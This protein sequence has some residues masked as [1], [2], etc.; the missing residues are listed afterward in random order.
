MKA[1][2]RTTKAYRALNSLYN[3]GL[4]QATKETTCPYCG[5]RMILKKHTDIKSRY[6]GMYYVCKSYPL[7]DTYCRAAEKNGAYHMISTPANKELRLLR[8][9]AHF[10]MNKLIETGICDTMD[11]VYFAI[12]QKVSI[13]NGKAIHIGYARENTCKEVIE[14]CIEALY[15]NRS[16]FARFAGFVGCPKSGRLWEM[17]KA[18][19]YRAKAREENC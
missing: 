14:Q 5:E 1:R 3:N 16:R 11:D 13:A 8:K 18:I 2:S 15:N 12:S 4:Y 10:W 6:P 17:T 9:E 19:S 7:C